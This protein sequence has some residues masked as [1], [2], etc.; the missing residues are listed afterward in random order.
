MTRF[1]VKTVLLWALGLSV[2]R[3]ALSAHAGVTGAIQWHIAGV[4]LHGIC[5]TLYFITAQVFLD[6]RVDPGMKGQAQGLLAMVSGGL[7]PLVGA[8]VCGRMRS[9]LVGEDGQ[10][11]TTFWAMLTLMI[12]LCFVIFA[13]FYQGRARQENTAAA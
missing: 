9:H 3:F 11:W 6:R 13:V 4:A 5:Y 8:V 10:G 1:R 7:G 12:A 2:L